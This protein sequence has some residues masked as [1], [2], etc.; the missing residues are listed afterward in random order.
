MPNFT[1]EFPA[2]GSRIQAWINVETES[3]AGILAQV[4]VW[5]ESWEA[6]FSRFR[7][8]SELSRLNANAGSWIAVSPEMGEVI[9]LALKAAAM[10]NGL[11]NPLILPALQSAGYE[12]SF[13]EPDFAPGLGLPGVIEVPDWRT[14]ELDIRRQ[15]VRLPMYA[16]LDLG[17]IVKGWAAQCAIDRLG[18]HGAC[19]VDAGGDMAAHG[20]PDDSDGWEVGIPRQRESPD[21]L[22]TVTLSETAIATS[23]IDHRHWTRAGQSL[24]HLIDPRT[25]QPVS[26]H[27]LTATV[28]ARD[29]IQAEAWA[30]ATLIS[31]D[32]VLPGRAGCAALIVHDD[33]SVSCNVQF[34]ELCPNFD[35]QAINR[36]ARLPSDAKL[37]P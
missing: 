28:I 6:R 25:A 3:Q 8:T 35:L 23:G 24:H 26:N 13:L 36:P 1:V 16:R 37:A 15:Q 9:G 27:V 5:F 7:P 17:G 32:S 2:M 29:G 12:R 14:I 31:G 19:L 33:L 10:T 34:E 11:F 22:C 18:E 30:K 21:V 20:S 4:P